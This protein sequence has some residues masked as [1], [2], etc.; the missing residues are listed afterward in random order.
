MSWSINHK[1]TRLTFSQT[2]TL[3][4]RA[5]SSY[6]EQFIGVSNAYWGLYLWGIEIALDE[7]I[8]I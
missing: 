1:L 4:L 7:L 5:Y 6:D 2:L 3:I 8:Y